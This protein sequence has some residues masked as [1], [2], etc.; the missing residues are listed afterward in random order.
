MSHTI[1]AAL[2]KRLAQEVRAQQAQQPAISTAEPGIRDRLITL[3]P[4]AQT[5]VYGPRL[6]HACSRAGSGRVLMVLGQCALRFLAGSPYF[7]PR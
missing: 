5:A 7:V 3:P 4:K 1:D 2:A 6:P